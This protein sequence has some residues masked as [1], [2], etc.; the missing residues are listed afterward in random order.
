MRE[1]DVN[2]DYVSYY[3]DKET[4]LPIVIGGEYGEGKYLYFATFFDPITGSG[5]GRFPY[6]IDLLKRQ[7]N[8]IPT[9]RRD[10][11]E[12]YFEP[13]DR[14]DI[15]IE[16]LIKHWR[17]NGVRRIYV[18]A[19]HFYENYAYDYERLIK[20]AHQNAMLV[21]A[22]L[23]FPHV[24]A[25]FWDDHPEWREYTAEGK[26]AII[27]WRRNMALNIDPCKQAIFEELEKLLSNYKWDGVNLA[28]L[29][30]E[31][32]HGFEMPQT[33]TP[34]N[35]QIR[36]TFR[37]LEGF[38]PIKLFDTGSK[39]YW[40]D[41]PEAKN[42]FSVFR[43]DQVV[44]LHREFL[45]FLHRFKS[46]AKSDLQI[47]V[48]TIDNMLSPQTGEGTGV[49]TNRIAELA[50]EFPF[51]LQIE[52]P[53]NL[54]H[55]GPERYTNILAAYSEIRKTTPLIL[56]IN[57]VPYRDMKKSNA[58]T[59]QPSGIE[60]YNLAK[61]ASSE[62][63][64]LALYSEASIYEVDFP[65]IPHVMA[66][67]AKEDLS[68]NSWTIESPYTVNFLIDADSHKD[69][70]VNGNF[71]P[72]YFKGKVILPKG[73]HRVESFS[74][75]KRFVKR[76]KSNTRLINLSGELKSLTAI[77]RGIEFEYESFESNIVIISDDPK[78]I[79][80]DG[81]IINPE[82]MKG[83]LGY[84]IRLPAGSHHTQIYTQTRGTQVLR[85]ISVFISGFIVFIGF[86]A[87]SV[88]SLIYI[89]NS[90]RRR[91]NNSG[92]KTI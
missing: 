89:K 32:Q 56:D 25:K 85:V 74:N 38:D 70:L 36:E 46:N 20:L 77:T 13:G 90:Y 81:K 71:W 14:E 21:Y 60:L 69:L 86:S 3:S 16:D 17:S 58:P 27:D 53:Q 57:V 54:W 5:Y 42:K 4:E 1:F 43:E 33:F 78:E 83:E 62:Q 44:S 40:K 28:E 51:T 59:Q 11:V 88:L 45:N 31:S 37:N 91:K 22:W 82:I 48:T 80:I 9:V 75:V 63:A 92:K 66:G 7:F 8:L 72:G 55:L 19:W 49:N 84:S 6:F 12:I 64:R 35:G 50:K 68:A 2:I 29:Y 39:Y 24:S 52:D 65:L 18:S 47:M 34:M 15:S 87:G 67:D 76:F 61:A 30:Y 23:E 73:K 79:L 26:E 41:N 10:A